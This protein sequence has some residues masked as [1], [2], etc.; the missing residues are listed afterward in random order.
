MNKFIARI[1]SLIRR[2]FFPSRLLENK[3]MSLFYSFK[4]FK[5]YFKFHYTI[6][7]QY[8]YNTSTIFYIIHKDLPQTGFADRLKVAVCLYYVAKQNGFQFRMIFEHPFSLPSYL[9]E[10]QVK[11][12]GNFNDL[13]YSVLNSRIVAYNGLSSIPRLNKKIKQYHIYT[14]LGY[15]L[16][17]HKVEN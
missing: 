1:K 13:N 12:V 16:S 5:L 14:M 15:K 8:K 11:W 6:Q 4:N 10:N 2:L 17:Y 7:V 9:S 3:I